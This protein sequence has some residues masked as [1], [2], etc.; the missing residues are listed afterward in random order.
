MRALDV[1]KRALRTYGGRR[2]VVLL[3]YHIFKNAGTTVELLLADNFGRHFRRFDS[4]DPFALLGEKDLL[5][6]LGSHPDVEAVSTHTLLPPKPQVAPYLFLDLLLVRHPLDRLGSVYSFY[7]RTKI[8]HDPLCEAARCLTAAQFFERLM[9]KY[10]HLVNNAQVNYLIGGRKVARQYDL[11][12]ALAVARACSVLGTTEMFD[13]CMLCAEQALQPYFGRLDFSY[14]PQNVT[15]GRPR[16]LNH[17]LQEMRRAC[18]TTLYDRLL[19]LNR[20]DLELFE[21]TSQEAE[22]RYKEI[23]H[24]ADRMADFV[25]RAE[26]RQGMM[27]CQD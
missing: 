21:W 2:R 5:D 20:L 11:Q 16:E 8:D 12:R 6:F 24:A 3:H 19:K 17:R 18:G 9:E 23:P 22:R 10:P 25:R 13:M 1:L 27:A 15:L 14:V 4:P 7:Q 26:K